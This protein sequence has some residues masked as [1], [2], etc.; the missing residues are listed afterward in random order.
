MAKLLKCVQVTETKNF[1]KL[2]QQ[3]EFT[4]L[5]LH[6]EINKISF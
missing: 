3:H 4:N 6:F 5:K 1:Q 2:C